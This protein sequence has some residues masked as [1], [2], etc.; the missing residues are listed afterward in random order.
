MEAPV[1]DRSLRLV[2]FASAPVRLASLANARMSWPQKHRITRELRVLARSLVGPQIHA[3]SPTTDAPRLVVT[4]R[5]IG[6]RRL[7][8][9]NLAGAFKPVRDGIA[10]ALRLDD[11]SERIAWRYEQR[12]AVSSLEVDTRGGYGIEIEIAEVLA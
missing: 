3:W 2:A 11:G 1:S 8:D 6:P 5:R 10:D 12:P 9:D 7:D 4:L